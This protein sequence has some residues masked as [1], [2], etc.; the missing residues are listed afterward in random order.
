MP[1]IRLQEYTTKI[2]KLI[3]DNRQDEAI[4]HCLHILHLY[5][6][7]IQS[8]R[9]LGEACLQKESLLEARDCFQRTLSADPEDVPA[10]IGLASTYEKEGKAAEALWLARRGLELAASNAEVRRKV[11]SLRAQQNGP[12]QVG[13]A[14][15]RLKLTRGALGRVYARNGL[16]ERAIGE[17]RAV[18]QKDSDL[19]EIRVAL[20]EALWRE[21]RLLEA[22]EVCVELLDKL[23]NC[24]KANLI[25]GTIELHSRERA[26][27]EARLSVARALDPENL[28][29][30]EMMGGESPLPFKEVFVPEWV[31]DVPLSQVEARVKKQSPVEEIPEWV[32]GLKM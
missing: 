17:F 7:H 31:T 30:Q 21:E 10:W 18:L 23:P 32:R 9:L 25:L 4:A 20:A 29:A 28:V 6:K 2:G 19:P 24:L 11:Q 27:G 13:T 14:E 1:N 8:Y 5:P 22:V 12:Y 16:Y 26:A 3:R 15:N